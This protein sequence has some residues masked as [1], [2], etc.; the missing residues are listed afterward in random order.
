MR[1]TKKQPHCIY[2]SRSITRLLASSIFLLLNLMY[3]SVTVA[4]L[5]P[6]ASAMVSVS[7]DFPFSGNLKEGIDY[8]MW[9]T[10][11][12][13]QKQKHKKIGCKSD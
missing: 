11:E 8:A 4:M 10:R 7:M 12:W 13:N 2:F 6:N 9:L 5:C 3:M 1:L